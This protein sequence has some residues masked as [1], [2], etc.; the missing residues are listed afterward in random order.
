MTGGWNHPSVAHFAI[1]A[2]ALLLGKRGFLGHN[3]PLFLSLAVARALFR[4]R[5][6][7]LPEA[8]FA[9][10]TCGGV[11]LAYALNSN[12]YSGP[13]CSIRWFVPLLAPLYCLLI[14]GLREDPAQLRPFLMLSGWG[15][16]LSG[17][18]WWKGPWMQHMIPGFWAIQAAAAA[19]WYAVSRHRTLRPAGRAASQVRAA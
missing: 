14:L 5:I 11:W 18:M 19:S 13:C 10:A 3:L 17:W 6:A 9:F 12:N 15:L 16:L 8:I 2:A 1:Y 4:K 7:E